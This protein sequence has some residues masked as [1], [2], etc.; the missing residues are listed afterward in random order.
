NPASQF[1]LERTFSEWRLSTYASS[2]VDTGGRF[3]GDV[4]TVSSCQD[5][6][7]PKTTGQVCFYGPQRTKVPRHE[8]SGA[9]AQVLD[10]IS[11]FSANDPGVDQD[12][13]AAG[14]ARSVSMLE[15][16]ASLD[17]SFGESVLAVR[18]TNE[19]GHKL[20]TG[21]IEGRRMWINVR[22]LDSTGALVG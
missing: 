14:R 1:P 17:L 22:Y 19:S 18:I 3:G 9:A 7:M 15:R 21:H 20:P 13:L 5:C 16:A 8:F 4:P 12:M 10:L 11:A 2:G 6:H